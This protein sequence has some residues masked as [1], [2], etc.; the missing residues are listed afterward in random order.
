[1]ILIIRRRTI[2]DIGVFF[3]LVRELRRTERCVYVEFV[4][5]D[6]TALK[7]GSEKRVSIEDV[8]IEDATHEQLDALKQAKAAYLNRYDAIEE[9][10]RAKH[11]DNRAA[12]NKSI[13]EITAS[14]VASAARARVDAEIEREQAK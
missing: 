3:A 13:Q 14:A 2:N 8:L 7:G 11:R 5:G 12:F 9:H 4:R 1:M 10:A 6:R